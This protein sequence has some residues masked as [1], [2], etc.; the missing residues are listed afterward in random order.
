M[1]THQDTPRVPRLAAQLPTT[2]DTSHQHRR[3]TEDGGAGEQ[4]QAG[5]EHH[6]EDREHDDEKGDADQWGA[7]SETNDADLHG[8]AIGV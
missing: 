2:E 5:G 6:G 8:W 4:R 3:A 7:R 1:L